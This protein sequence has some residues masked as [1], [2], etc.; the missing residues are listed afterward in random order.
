M[1]MMLNILTRDDDEN[2]GLFEHISTTA[3]GRNIDCLFKCVTFPCVH[4]LTDT[5]LLRLTPEPT[6]ATTE[7]PNP[8]S[9]Q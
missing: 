7:H 2:K 5:G 9:V 4:S 1:N 6:T 8:F 3:T